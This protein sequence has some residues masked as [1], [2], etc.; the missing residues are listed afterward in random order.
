MT[1]LPNQIGIST[2][3]A[4][5]SLAYGILSA[6]FL[7]KILIMDSRNKL[8]MMK[9][10]RSTQKRIPFKGLE[11]YPLSW[12]FDF[13]LMGAVSTVPTL[14]ISTWWA[15][16]YFP[17]RWRRSWLYWALTW[18][19]SLWQGSLLIL[20]SF[21]SRKFAKESW[22]PRITQ[23]KNNPVAVF[24]IY[25]SL[26]MQKLYSVLYFILQEACE[27]QPWWFCLATQSILIL[28]RK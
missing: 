25:V 22:H 7:L 5:F 23:M 15:S 20:M 12:F 3:Q 18:Q 11:L 1:F 24:R 6:L 2:V 21:S 10:R 13:S 26:P 16:V 28:R 8:Q 9:C 14:S 4:S 17:M 19:A 27:F